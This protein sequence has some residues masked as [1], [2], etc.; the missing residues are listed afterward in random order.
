MSSWDQANREEKLGLVWRS[1]KKISQIINDYLYHTVL[2]LNYF[3][4]ESL[5]QECEA[6]PLTKNGEG[7]EQLAKC[8]AGL[9]DYQAAQCFL[10]TV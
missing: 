6:D 5:L 3:M 9:L 1:R 2:P 4:A 10:R 8:R 7:A